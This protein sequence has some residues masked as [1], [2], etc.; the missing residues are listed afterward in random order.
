[1]ITHVPSGRRYI[2]SSVNI[3]NRWT[4]HL[5]DLKFGKH[6]SRHLQRTWDKYGES[7]FVF[8][9]LL[10]CETHELIRYEQWFID[11]MNPEFNG[12]KIAGSTLG[13][14]HSE[15]TRA[16][17]GKHMIGKKHSQE[18]KDKISAAKTGRKVTFSE[19]HR[20]SMSV[21]RTGN[22]LSEFHCQRISEGLKG[23]KRS[24]LSEEH[25]RNLSIAGKGKKKSDETRKRMSET[26]MG[27][28][29][30]PETRAKISESL[31]RRNAALRN[32]NASNTT[33]ES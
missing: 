23:K 32:N 14:K 18:T 16:K 4:E 11:N 26:W 31:K 2:G 8:S 9:V 21:A 17:M 6:H 10:L 27:H 13:F 5:S 7:D 29:T 20:A 19:S 1:M 24:P 33:T 22:H 3:G 28:V 25:R 12:S 30:S 15:E